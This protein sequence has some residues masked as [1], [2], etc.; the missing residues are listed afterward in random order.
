MTLFTRG[1][2]YMTAAPEARPAIVPRNV[3]NQPPFFV[4]PASF[5]AMAAALLDHGSDATAEDTRRAVAESIAICGCRSAEEVA[6][7]AV[8]LAAL[9]RFER[10]LVLQRPAARD[11]VAEVHVRQPAPRRLVDQA[12][13]VPGAER[14]SPFVRFVEEVNRRESG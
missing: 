8:V 9:V 2:T 13:H 6:P 12:Q 7:D 11:V 1:V 5:S 10:R 14:P 4:S 3:L